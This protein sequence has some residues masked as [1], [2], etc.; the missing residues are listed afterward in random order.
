MSSVVDNLPFP[1]RY[2]FG[3]TLKSDQIQFLSNAANEIKTS[4]NEALPSLAQHVS[5]VPIDN[6]HI[7]LAAPRQITENEFKSWVTKLPQ[8][9]EE[10]ND[11]PESKEPWT[12][13]CPNHLRI[14]CTKY[15]D[16]NIQDLTT[17]K[18]R[19][20]RFILNDHS[21]SLSKLTIFSSFFST[22]LLLFKNKY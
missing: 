9:V 5:V 18:V 8:I 16:P 17:T 12:F 11:L 10:I 22:C 20:V 2:Y 14:Q 6:L 13:S 1:G 15:P 3:V 21:C 7:T 4:I 19:T